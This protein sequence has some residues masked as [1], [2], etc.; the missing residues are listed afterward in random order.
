MRQ[1]TISLF[2]SHRKHNV[3]VLSQI[4]K[5]MCFLFISLSLSPPSE[6]T[7]DRGLPL[8]LGMRAQR[9]LSL[10]L[11]F[12]QKFSLT[13]RLAE[14]SVSLR[15]SALSLC[16]SQRG[17]NLSLSIRQRY[18]ALEAMTELILS[19]SMRRFLSLSDTHKGS[20]ILAETKTAFSLSLW[21]PLRQR[22]KA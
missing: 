4:G 3:S 9:S 14:L 2:P 7:N 16:L 10:S 19:P 21:L 11:S 13:N 22:V 15:G 8:S 1:S 20:R 6:D 12:K 18:K 17:R 5:E